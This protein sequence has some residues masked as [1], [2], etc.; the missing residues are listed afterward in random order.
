[1]HLAGYG[2]Q[3]FSSVL[4]FLREAEQRAP[5]AIKGGMNRADDANALLWYSVLPHAFPVCGIVKA[6]VVLTSPGCSSDPGR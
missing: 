4:S 3:C 6:L 5:S 2:V 1:M